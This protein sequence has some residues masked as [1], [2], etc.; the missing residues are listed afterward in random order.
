M[1]E[2]Y[3]PELRRRFLHWLDGERWCLVCQAW[4]PLGHPEDHAPLPVERR[5][6]PRRRYDDTDFRRRGRRER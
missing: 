4:A 6:Q 1:A 3:R 2:R 5:P